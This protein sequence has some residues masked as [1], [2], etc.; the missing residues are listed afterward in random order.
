MPGLALDLCPHLPLACTSLVLSGALIGP[1]SSGDFVG[2]IGALQ[3]RFGERWGVQE[4]LWLGGAGGQNFTSPRARRE[5]CVHLRRSPWPRQ[6]RIYS[7]TPLSTSLPRPVFSDLFQ[8]LGQ[9]AYLL[10]SPDEKNQ[11]SKSFL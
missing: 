2:C 6:G 11:G 9:G 7:Y 8:L 1:I 10:H 5:A 4:A 3:A